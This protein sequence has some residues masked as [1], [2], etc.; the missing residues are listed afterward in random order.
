M[1]T[2]QPARRGNTLQDPRHMAEEDH[3][4]FALQYYL[5]ALGTYNQA[6]TVLIRQLEPGQPYLRGVYVVYSYSHGL[7]KLPRTSK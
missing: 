5:E 3:N 4:M 6:I 2:E 1:K 7:V